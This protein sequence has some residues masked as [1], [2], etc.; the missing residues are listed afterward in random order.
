MCVLINAGDY[1]GYVLA[2][3]NLFPQCGSDKLVCNLKPRREIF[4]VLLYGVMN[5]GIIFFCL[6]R[7]MDRLTG[8]YLL[9][10]VYSFFALYIIRNVYSFY[11]T[12]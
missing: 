5:I 3:C 4:L 8:T 9:Q 1:V 12:N 7:K 11:P 6:E 2:G 10:K